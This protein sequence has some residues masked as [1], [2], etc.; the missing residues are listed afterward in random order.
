MKKTKHA[1]HQTPQPKQHLAPPSAGSGRKVLIAIALLLLTAGGT[2][3]FTEF[4]VWNRLPGN[5]VGR[6]EVVQGP[7]EYKDAVFEFHRS[8][9]MIAYVNDKGN[10]GEIHADIRVEGDKI[11]STSRHPRSGQEHVTV[12]TIRSLT[13]QDLIVADEAGRVTKMA[14]MN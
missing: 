1:K 2:W 10:V 7:P 8:G 14:R 12:Q 9:K 11:Y 13:D 4:V 5:L 3:A 6:W